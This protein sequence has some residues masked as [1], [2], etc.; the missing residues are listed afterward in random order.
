MAS[1]FLCQAASSDNLRWATAA[2]KAATAAKMACSCKNGRAGR[3]DLECGALVHFADVV[4]WRALHGGDVP[5]D[6][7]GGID[8][9]PLVVVAR[10]L[11]D[12]FGRH[13][14]GRAKHGLR[15]LVGVF[16]RFAKAKISNFDT[17]VVHEDVVRLDIC[18]H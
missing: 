12:D 6:E 14:D 13:V 8:I 15:K 1:L 5:H 16:E 2:A 18:V 17:S 10:A 9:A 3:R 11:G 7:R 4:G